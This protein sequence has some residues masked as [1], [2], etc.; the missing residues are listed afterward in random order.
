ML[1]LKVNGH[2]LMCYMAEQEI[3]QDALTKRAKITARTVQKAIRGIGIQP[4]A[5]GK[6]ANALGVSLGDLLEVQQ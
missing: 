5:I 2:K 1:L 6:I 3:T 4:I